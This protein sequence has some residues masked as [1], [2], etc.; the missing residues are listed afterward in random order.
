MRVVLFCGGLG[1]RSREHPDTMPKRLV[2]VGYRPLI[3]HLVRTTP[4]TGTRSVAG[5]RRTYAPS[6]QRTALR[7]WNAS[8]KPSSA[9]LSSPRSRINPRNVSAE[10]HGFSTWLL[11]AESN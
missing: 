1:T 10:N 2:N 8:A 7:A 6:A 5:D 4:T 9:L 11:Y 3:W